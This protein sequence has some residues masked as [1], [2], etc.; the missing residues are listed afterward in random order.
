[1]D[2]INI[3][4]KGLV[5]DLDVEKRTGEYWDFP[6]LNIRI[7]NHEGQGFIVTYDKGNTRQVGGVTVGATKLAV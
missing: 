2:N 5:S 6:T 3:F 7:L 1:M 4:T